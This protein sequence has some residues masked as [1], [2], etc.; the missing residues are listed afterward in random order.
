[1]LPLCLETLKLNDIG[2]KLHGIYLSKNGK[3][4]DSFSWTGHITWHF[5][6]QGIQT[7]QITICN[8]GVWIILHWLHITA[9][10]AEHC[11]QE[12][13]ANLIQFNQQ[14]RIDMIPIFRSY[15]L[16][17]NWVALGESRGIESELHKLFMRLTGTRESLETCTEVH[18]L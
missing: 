10:C 9:G 18:C 3:S 6:L 12:F 4:T 5:L 13:P 14:P 1:M 15:Y 8:I 7:L 16:N 11:K 17:P 2:W